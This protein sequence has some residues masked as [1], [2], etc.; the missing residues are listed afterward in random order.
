MRRSV[1]GGRGRGGG[2][3]QLS[4]GQVTPAYLR[5]MLQKCSGGIKCYTNAMLES[6]VAQMQRGNALAHRQGLV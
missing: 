5:K 4:V 1:N 6:N 2:R 3:H